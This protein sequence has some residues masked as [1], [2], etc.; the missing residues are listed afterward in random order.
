[1]QSFIAASQRKIIVK[2]QVKMANKFKKTEIDGFVLRIVLFY[3]FRIKK[4][5]LEKTRPISIL[6]LRF[7]CLLKLSVLGSFKNIANIQ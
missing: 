5:K 1:M 6:L 4:T 7:N 2:R 3:N